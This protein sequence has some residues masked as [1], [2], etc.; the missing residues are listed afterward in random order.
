MKKKMYVAPEL[1]Q[2]DLDWP[3]LLAGSGDD[4]EESGASDNPYSGEGL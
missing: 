1:E 2:M 4:P 3:V